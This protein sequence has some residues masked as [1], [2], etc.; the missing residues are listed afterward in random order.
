MAA[1]R[2][3][4]V[5]SGVALGLRFAL[6]SGVA[7]R[8][9]FALGSGVRV[10]C[11][12]SASPAVALQ[13]R[14]ADAASAA[15]SSGS[16]GELRLA[17]AAELQQLVDHVRKPV[18]LEQRGVEVL[19]D[20]RLAARAAGGLDVQAGPGERGAELMRRIG[21]EIPLRAHQPF[22]LRGHVVERAGER[23]LPA[24]ALD[25]RPRCSCHACRIEALDGDVMHDPEPV[26]RPRAGSALL[27]CARPAGV[28]VLDA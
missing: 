14:A 18:E 20:F 15:S 26:E 12:A 22:E 16:P 24:A 27:C 10:R 2:G 11:G 9:R 13:R 17:R 23:L 6:G 25:G 8:L 19:V 1:D 3:V 28:V 7:L 4:V 21:D 5:G